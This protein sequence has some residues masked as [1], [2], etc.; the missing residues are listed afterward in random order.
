[1]IASIRKE[2]GGGSPCNVR[3]M[4]WKHENFT[5]LSQMGMRVLLT[6]HRQDSRVTWESYYCFRRAI[7]F[8]LLCL[9]DS[10]H[11]RRRRQRIHIY[12]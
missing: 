8:T 5:A 10:T 3:V 12:I 2:V 7:S 11:R 4:L 6:F 9:W 1:M